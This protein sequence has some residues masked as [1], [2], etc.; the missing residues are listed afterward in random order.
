VPAGFTGTGLPVGLQLV[1]PWYAEDQLLGAA[2]RLEA[3]HAWHERRP[4]I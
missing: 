2:A 1:G 4:P 3:I